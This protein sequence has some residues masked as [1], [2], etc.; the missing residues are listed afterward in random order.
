MKLSYR[1]VSPMLYGK[2]QDVV[3]DHLLCSNLSTV[4]NES[5]LKIFGNYY[6]STYIEKNPNYESFFKI[7]SGFV[8]Q[9]IVKNIF[10]PRPDILREKD[11]WMLKHGIFAETGRYLVSLQIRNNEASSNPLI[12]RREWAAFRECA[13]VHIPAAV[14]AS[15]VVWFVATDS[16]VSRNISKTM[17]WDRAIS[18]YGR[19]FIPANEMQGTQ[20]NVC[21]SIIY[22]H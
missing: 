8:G 4:W 9:I 14:V 21:L 1:H 2:L 6:F 7:Y 11:K 22:Y 15:H 5:V 16:E 19:T 13:L 10:I 17:F 3:V 18:F 20:A 12:S